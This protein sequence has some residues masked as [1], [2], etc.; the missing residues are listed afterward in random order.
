MLKETKFITTK[1]FELNDHSWVDLL[2]K[3]LKDRGEPEELLK[4]GLFETTDI[5]KLRSIPLYV[6]IFRHHMVCDDGTPSVNHNE[7][8]AIVFVDSL[9]WPVEIGNFGGYS[10]DESLDELAND[11]Y[12]GRFAEAIADWYIF[13]CKKEKYIY[14]N[15]QPAEKEPED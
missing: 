4:Y 8:N 11:Y 5:E 1:T 10:G 6:T 14:C 2:H 15:E 12:D 9:D 13:D 7:C 3:K